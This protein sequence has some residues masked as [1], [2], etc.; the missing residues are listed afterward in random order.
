M[1]WSIV[2]KYYLVRH[3][4]SVIML[5]TVYSYSNGHVRI[6]NLDKVGILQ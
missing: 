4:R 3:I 2:F 5:V 1:Q 6:Y